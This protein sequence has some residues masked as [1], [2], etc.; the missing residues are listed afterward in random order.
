MLRS[1]YSATSGMLAQQ[2]H[3]D[4]TS[5]NIAN[6]NT[7]GFKKSRADFN[8]LFYQAMQYAGTNTSNTTLSPDGMEVGLGVRP[9]AI[10]KMFSQGSPKETEN[11][12]D[13]AITGKGFFQVQLPDG[14]T[15]YTRSGNF[16]LDEQGNL[17]TSEGYLL[18]PQ[19]TL[20]EDTTQVNIGVDGTVSVTQGLQT[21]SNV[22]GQITLANFV[23]PA[24]LH[25]MGDNLFSITNA[26]GDAIVGNPDSQGLGKLRQGFLELSNVR[27]VE[28]MT[29]LITAQRAYEAN[30]KSIQTA[31]SMLQ[32]VN[33]LK[34]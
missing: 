19:I 12:L 5:N 33:S 22:I 14:T 25:S 20:P 30:S 32:T 29:D 9:S 18:I 10:T 23:N 26:S 7:T 4:T 1:L 2:T 28:E 15:A 31:D 27:L 13:I 11:N 24:G 34:R 8:D 17:V 6:V 21:T 3:I 16:K